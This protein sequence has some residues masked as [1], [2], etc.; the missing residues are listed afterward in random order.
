MELGQW[1]YVVAYNDALKPE[2]TGPFQG[3]GVTTQGLQTA[4]AEFWMFGVSDYRITSRGCV[5]TCS[6]LSSKIVG[7][8]CT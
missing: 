2:H 8:A 4:A 5:T 1:N 7:T 3:F 6:Q